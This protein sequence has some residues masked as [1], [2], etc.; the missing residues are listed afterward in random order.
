MDEFNSLDSIN[1]VFWGSSTT[2][3]QIST[4]TINNNLKPKISSYNFG[5]PGL[6]H[7]E[8]Y[9]N[10]EQF[11][12]LANPNIKYA[13]LELNRLRFTEAENLFINRTSY[14]LTLSN[15]IYATHQII[16]EKHSLKGKLYYMGSNISN[17]LYKKLSL[18]SLRHRVNPLSSELILDS[19][20]MQLGYLS[21]DQELK[22]RPDDLE[23]L[24]RNNRLL[25]N[26]NF[27]KPRIEEV[28][29]AYIDYEDDASEKSPHATK[30]K[31]LLDNSQERG[32]E[33]FFIIPPH[34]GF[35]QN[36]IAYDSYKELL[37]LKKNIS[38]D[39]FIDLGNPLD[40]PNLYE[41]ENCFDYIHLNAKGS[42]IYTQIIIEEIGI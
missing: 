35:Y 12:N 30:L 3:R 6:T 19:K 24:K 20:S 42:E 34:L 29:K 25:K 5:T 23:L 16:Y 41:N 15:L 40:Y 21:L 1:T 36:S 11:I 9:Y 27:L 13:F 32:I 10:Y 14:A 7:L 26:P 2:F 28:K 17:Y 8:L 18:S 38:P 22:S 39:R 37:A 4:P 31:E 33:L